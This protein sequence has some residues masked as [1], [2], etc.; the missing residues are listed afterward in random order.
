MTVRFLRCWK[1]FLYIPKTELHSLCTCVCSCACEVRGPWQLLFSISFLWDS[2][3]HWPWCLPFWLVWLA[4]K[5]QDLHHS[6]APGKETTAG[7]SGCW[8]SDRRPCMSH[9]SG[10]WIPSFPFLV[11]V[12]LSDSILAPSLHQVSYIKFHII[13]S[14]S[15]TIIG[16]L[17]TETVT[18][19]LREQSEGLRHITVVIC[20]FICENCFWKRLWT[21]I[22]PLF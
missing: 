21:L 14:W 1:K 2:I 12:S 4:G 19:W 18:W 22:I 8:E 10:P 9:L 15:S 6:L 20:L 16:K 7:L 3:S 13:I 11:F 5:P 17:N